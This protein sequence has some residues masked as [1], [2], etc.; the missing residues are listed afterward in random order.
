MRATLAAITEYRD[1]RTA[2]RFFIDV[3]LGIQ[4]H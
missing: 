2:Q 4:T 1:A 3:L